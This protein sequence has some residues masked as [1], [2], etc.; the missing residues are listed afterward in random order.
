MTSLVPFATAMPKLRSL[1]LQSQ[2]LAR[3][4]VLTILALVSMQYAA[5]TPKDTLA[6]RLAACTYCHGEQGRAGPDGY[7]PR[8]AGK[9]AAYLYHQLLNFRDGRRQYRPMN[10]LLQNLDEAYLREIAEF[11]S[12][13]KAPYPE[14]VTATLSTEQA[15]R[16]RT[17]VTQGDAQR[18]VPACTACHGPALMGALPATPALLGLPRDYL[19]AQL[20]AWQN[21]LRQAHAPDC[22]GQ[23]AQQLSVDDV[24]TMSAWLSSQP[25]PANYTVTQPPKA[26]PLRCGSALR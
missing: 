23:I 7:Y 9:P 15:Q 19:I 4:W 8:L 2:H 20:G 11:F 17:L 12:T 10:Q 1:I 25:V 14:P 21:G 24:A 3:A 5:A 6:Q 18:K 13:Q 22:M 26:L 16:A